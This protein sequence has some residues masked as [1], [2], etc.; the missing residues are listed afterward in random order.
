MMF[1]LPFSR[2]AS[3]LYRFFFSLQDFIAGKGRNLLK[4]L[5][6]L[7]K[8]KGP[9]FIGEKVSLA[10]F[11]IMNIWLTLKKAVGELTKD[12]PQFNAHHD[13]VCKALPKVAEYVAARQ[14]TPI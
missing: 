1:L 6:G 10:D 2:V 8:E 9:F 11:C 13:A 4:Q 7:L 12:F 3:L 5:S 14:D